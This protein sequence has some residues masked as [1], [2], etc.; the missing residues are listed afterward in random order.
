L[1][2]KI[3]TTLAG[4]VAVAALAVAGMFYHGAPPAHA[5]ATPK[6]P[7]V[8]CTTLFA[9]QCQ[10][11]VVA[12]SLTADLTPAADFAMH[13]SGPSPLTGAAYGNLSIS[14]DNNLLNGTEDLVWEHVGTVPGTGSF[15]GDGI[16]EVKYAPNGLDTNWCLTVSNRFRTAGLV[17]GGCQAGNVRQ[18]FIVTQT[19]PFLA[20]LTGPTAAYEYAFQVAPAANAQGH[21]ALVYPGHGDGSLL[22]VGNAPHVAAGQPSPA[23]WS[24]IHN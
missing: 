23:E 16:Y 13:Y 5:S 1:L 9:A 14:F 6:L 8:A 2:R 24:S 12:D 3:L 21:A 22:A 17:L 11:P 19:A 15:G 4:A 20:T 10:E 7:T 18:G